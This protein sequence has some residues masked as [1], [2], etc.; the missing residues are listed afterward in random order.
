M[1]R[2]GRMEGDL[3]S[4]GRDCVGSGSQCQLRTQKSVNIRRRLSEFVVK[5]LLV[6]GLAIVTLRSR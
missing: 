4:D 5:Q 3:L 1:I 2:G 6:W